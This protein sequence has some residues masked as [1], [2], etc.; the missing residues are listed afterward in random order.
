MGLGFSPLTSAAMAL[1]ANTATVAFGAIG[2]PIIGLSASSGIDTMTLG[3][4]IGI[5][6]MPSTLM[7][8]L[9]MLW[10]FCGWKKTLAV[11]PAIV[12]AAVSFA[13]PQFIFSYYIS[14]FIVDVAAGGISLACFVGFMRVWKP[15]QVMT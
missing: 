6:S 8:P 5:Q 10:V 2:A 9:F 13:I 14:P 1:F 15:A 11:W 7:M 12:V 3:K 4:A